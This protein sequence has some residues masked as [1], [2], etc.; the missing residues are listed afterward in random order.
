VTGK[1]E[2]LVPMVEGLIFRIDLKDSLIIID[3]EALHL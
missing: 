1:E 3:E 2:I